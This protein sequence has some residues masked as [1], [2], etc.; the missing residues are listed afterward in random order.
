MIYR[1]AFLAPTAK[2]ALWLLMNLQLTDQSKDHRHIDLI[3][4]MSALIHSSG[5]VPFERPTGATNGNIRTEG[6]LSLV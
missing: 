3:P 2:L 5:D 4:G 1:L 6:M